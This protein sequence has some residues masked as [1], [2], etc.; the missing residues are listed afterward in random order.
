M[1]NTRPIDIFR[2]SIPERIQLAEDLWDSIAAD[3]H[4]VPLTEDQQFVLN[5]RL[6]DYAQNPDEG[7][8]WDAVR[9]RLWESV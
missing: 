3:Q 7:D 5:E 9:K 4:T 1:Q 6:A 8:S 2:L